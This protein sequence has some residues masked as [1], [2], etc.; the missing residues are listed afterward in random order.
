MSAYMSWPMSAQQYRPSRRAWVKL[1]V[2][3]FLGG[4]VRWQLTLAEQGM[5]ATLMCLA[6]ASR[7]PG[8][9]ASGYE[10]DS[11]SRMLGYPLIWL[12]NQI[13]TTEADLSTVLVKLQAQ[14][15]V[16]VLEQTSLLGCDP[17]L[18]VVLIEIVGWSKYQSEYQL[19]R[20][21]RKYNEPARHD[22][23]YNV[24]KKSN[25]TPP[26]EVEVEEEVELFSLQNKENNPLTPFEK[27]WENYPRKLGVA[28]ARK[29]WAKLKQSD[30]EAAI[31][32][33]AAWNATEQWK[34]KSKIPYGSTFLSKR[35][36][37]DEPRSS[38]QSDDP[39]DPKGLKK[40]RAKHEE[41]MRRIAEDEPKPVGG[42]VRKKT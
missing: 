3:E 14:H 37:D 35:R 17:D 30:R 15:R 18:K 34:D 42:G 32:S 29:L 38:D 19:K 2:N 5:W 16:A 11:R 13:G 6:G 33:L 39:F 7:F 8:F 23:D 28:E 25:K 4:T 21:R 10:S 26:Q 12:A 36:M 31:A 41:L 27:F 24:H 40:E 1:W 20:Q 22:G 9:I